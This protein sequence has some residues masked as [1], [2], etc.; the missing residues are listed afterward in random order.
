MD[1]ESRFGAGFC[2]E[3]NI[4]PRCGSAQHEDHAGFARFWKNP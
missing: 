4:A 1:A 3:R 2:G